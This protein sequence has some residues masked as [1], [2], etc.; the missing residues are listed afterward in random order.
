MAK[1]S[2]PLAS[3]AAKPARN[4]LSVIYRPIEHAASDYDPPVVVWN[5]IKFH[6][7]IPVELNP[8]NRAHYIEQLIPKQFVS[9]DGEV[10]TKHLPQMVF[11]GELAKHNSSFEV[12]GF[13]RA[14]HVMP[15]V[16]L[17][18]GKKVRA[19]VPPAGAEWAGTNRADLIPAG[20]IDYPDDFDP[21]AAAIEITTR[22]AA[23]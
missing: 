13:A 6:A 16:T 17:A 23:A 18:D 14:K 8:R 10:R 21:A 5:K 12:E 20:E 11:M 9:G 2:K 22:N 4:T 1:T 15:T 3:A 7:N 19:T